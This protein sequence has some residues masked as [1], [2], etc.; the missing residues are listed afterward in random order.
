MKQEGLQGIPSR[1]R[2]RRG[3]SGIRP[4]DVTN[5]LARDFGAEAHNTKWVT[6]MTYIR[7]AE[8]WL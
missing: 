4:Q 7:T 5:H 3:K 8:G 6:D 2:W 1:K